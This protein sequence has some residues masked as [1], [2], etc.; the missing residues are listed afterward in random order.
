VVLEADH[1]GMPVRGVRSHGALTL[2][3]AVRGAIRHGPRTGDE[4]SAL[5]GAHR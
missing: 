3:S 4:F 2:T 1:T 5:T